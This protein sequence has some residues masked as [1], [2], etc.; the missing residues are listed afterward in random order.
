MA[1]TLIERVEID[2]ERNMDIR[3]KYRDE[4]EALTAYLEE[5]E[6]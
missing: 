1:H 3:F 6:P 5:D 4:Y 2:S